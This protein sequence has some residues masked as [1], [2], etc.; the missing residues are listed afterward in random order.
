[1]IEG[2][3]LGTCKVL[4]VDDQEPNRR[5]L[6]SLVEAM[7]IEQIEYAVDGVDGLAKIESFR[8]DLVLLDIMMPNMDGFTMCRELRTRPEWR[9]LPV[10][11]NT[12]LSEPGERV[13]CFKAGATDMVTKPINGPEVLARVRLHLERRLLIQSLSAYHE[14]VAQELALAAR[15]Q[16]EILPKP[17]RLEALGE[18]C[19]LRLE[20][21]Y[22]PS[23]ELGSD[24]WELLDLGPD[25]LGVLLVDFSGHG[26]GAAL[27]AFRLHALIGRMPPGRDQPPSEWLRVLNGALKGLLGPGQFATAIYLV[28]DTASDEIRYASAAAP[29]PL[30]LDAR[31]QAAS[32]D[33]SGFFLGIIAGVDYEDRKAAFPKGSSLFLYSD[34]LVESPDSQGRPLGEADLVDFVLPDLTGAGPVLPGLVKRIEGRFPPPL[35]DDLTLVRI[36]RP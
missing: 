9:D 11:V 35:P 25:R 32:L 22:A 17:Q 18:T 19:G 15:M 26:V 2:P 33:S 34:A 12:A 31:G 1:M 21:Y 27:N 4:I 14:R 5:L 23:S 7:G 10:L 36:A 16:G 3:D 24:F 30:L 28:F 6:G 13:E 8:P 29:A 20:S